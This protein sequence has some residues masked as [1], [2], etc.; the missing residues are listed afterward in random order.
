[1]RA[2]SPGV[3][4]STLLIGRGTTHRP[5]CLDSF[6]EA[7]GAGQEPRGTLGHD[8][9]ARTSSKASPPHV[10]ESTPSYTETLRREFLAVTQTPEKGPLGRYTW[11]SAK[12]SVPDSLR[13]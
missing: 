13:E 2:T 7:L 12:S 11:R 9:A 5:W 10:K 8:G 1:M 6:K 3:S 4:F